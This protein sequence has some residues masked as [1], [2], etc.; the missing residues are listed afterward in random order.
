MN[1]AA[2]SL[3]RFRTFYGRPRTLTDP[4]D[5]AGEAA[6]ARV[7]GRDD[8]ELTWND[9]NLL[10]RVGVASATYEEGLWFLPAALAFLRRHPNPHAVD[11]V[12]DVVWFVSEHAVRLEQDGLLTACAAEVEALLAERTRAFMLVEPEP[13][14][15]SDSATRAARRR[16]Y[17]EDADLVHECVGALQRFCTLES[18]AAAFLRRLGESVGEPVKSAWYIDGLAKARWSGLFRDPAAPGGRPPGVNSV[19]TAFPE[20][21]G[22]W[23]EFEKRGLIRDR[24]AVLDPGRAELVRHAAT[25]RGAEALYAGHREFWEQRFRELGLE[26]EG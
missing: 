15:E 2:S 21:N 25:V 12:A 14:P 5:E 23:E 16:A 3:E 8:D 7:L 13:E 26:P 18:W 24:P 9:F 6:T 10:Y 1:R 11:C 20:L 17:V 22:L 19:C 4:Y